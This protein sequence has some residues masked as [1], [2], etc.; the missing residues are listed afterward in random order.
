MKTKPN[1]QHKL[2]VTS[3]GG[4]GTTMLIE[5]LNSIGASLPTD[6]DSGEWKHLPHP[7]TLEDYSI[8][9]DFK[10]IYLIG[11]PVDSLLSVFRRGYHRWHALRMRS[12]NRWPPSIDLSDSPNPPSWGIGEFVALKKDCFG[13]IKHFEN[14]TKSTK[15]SRG[16]PIMIIKYETLCDNLT[17]LSSFIGL[18][19]TQIS[20]FPRRRAR[21]PRSRE[22][23]T[24]RAGLIEIYGELQKVIAAMPAHSII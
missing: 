4:T 11:D 13:I 1:I 17:A 3:F 2:Q 9:Q 18:S 21:A 6:P 7:P 16:Y 12:E 8:P 23:E 5:W 10:A 22:L 14:W 24:G 15:E 19:K 20:T